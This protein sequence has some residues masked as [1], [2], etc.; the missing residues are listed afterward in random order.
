ME[1]AMLARWREGKRG[2]GI[3][4]AAGLA[5]AALAAV[6]AAG[7]TARP[8]DFLHLHSNLSQTAV[9]ISAYPDLAV[10]PDGDRVVAAW[11]EGYKEG[12]GYK[13]HVYLR[14]A[15]GAGVSWGSKVPVFSGGDSTCAYDVAVAI[16]D[17]TAHVAYV[18]FN[19][20]CSD[21]TQ[22]QVRYRACSLA[23]LASGQCDG[24]EDIVASADTLFNR[25]TWVDLAVDAS[26]NPHVV[27]ARY[28]EQGH[29]GEILY[30]ARAGST[31]GSVST[32]GSNAGGK[33]NNAPAIAWADGSVHVV[34]EEETW[35]GEDK[36]EHV[37]RYRRR[38]A[39]GW[40]SS[41]YMTP[42][43]LGTERPPSN[44]GVAAGKG[45]VF[46]VWDWCSN[47]DPNSPCSTY[48]T[49]YR[50][51]NSGGVYWGTHD[52]E[53]REVGTDYQRSYAYDDLEDY[54]SVLEGQDEYVRRLRPAI[55][56]NKDGWPA[57]V[58]HA[59]R[60]GGGG[61]EGGGSGESYAI[62]YSY[63]ISGTDSTVDW[64]TTTV[65][66]EEQPN[67]LASAAVA[68]GAR[69]GEQRLHAAYMRKPSK[70]SPDAWDVYYEGFSYNPQARIHVAGLVLVSSTV[71]L[72]GSGSY[73]PLGFPLTY[74]WSLTGKPAGSVAALSAPSAVLPTITVD[75][76]G[77]YTVT[78]EV[79][80]GLMTSPLA[81]RT[82]LACEM[83]CGVY[84]PLVLRGGL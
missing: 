76:I 84:L 11:T 71:T 18:V 22:M 54:D 53:I 46:V 24:S 28:D 35:V 48:H 66:N 9:L 73:D 20:T 12:V 19:N 43:G 37:L 27:W 36:T 78:L 31:W 29:D 62:C 45:Q 51:S 52:S 61:E 77:Y 33:N 50:R 38:Q 72:D 17:T 60:N 55:A 23:S 79:D 64:I 49:V 16:T 70:D 40:D 74:D 69:D 13:G 4:L 15:S 6:L 63:A 59:K 25:I 39:S 14:A 67:W 3:V 30:S 75:V 1:V 34:W 68:V 56:L 83:I 7:A 82:I 32:V 65:L 10:S 47:E 42:F 26:G 41:V 2:V 8:L 5:A 21:P 80:N 44:P 58:W 81:T 57:V